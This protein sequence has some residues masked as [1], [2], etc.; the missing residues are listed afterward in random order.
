LELFSAC[1]PVSQLVGFISQLNR[2]TAMD[3]LQIQ[4]MKLGTNLGGGIALVYGG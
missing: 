2:T 3:M 4:E 1:L